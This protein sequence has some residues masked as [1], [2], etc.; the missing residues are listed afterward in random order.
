[1]IISKVATPSMNG[2]SEMRLNELDKLPEGLLDLSA[3]QLHA[4]LGGPTLI[5]MPGRQNPALY[6][7]VLM[8]GNED[9]GWEAIRGL[10]RRYQVGGGEQVLPRSLSLFIGNTAAAEVGVRHLEDQPDFN[11]IWPGCEN[12]DRPEHKVMAQVFDTMVARGLFA[13]IDVHNNTGMNPHHACINAINTPTLHMATLFSR[14]VVYFIRPKGVQSIAMTEL[15]P[16]I[17]LECGKVGMKH[18]V[19]HA[20][21]YIDAMLHLH[22]HPQHPVPKHDIDLFHHV[23]RVKVSEDTPFTFGEGKSQLNLMDD[24]ERM[25]FR[26]LA[27]GTRFAY[28]HDSPDFPL[29]VRNEQ[30][31]DVS[32]LY[33]EVV[34]GQL[35]TRTPVMPSMLTMDEMVIRQD[36]LCYLMERYDTHIDDA[37]EI[38]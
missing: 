21:E 7:S 37:L 38:T 1:M 27:A 25:N 4:E 35:R 14:T 12:P 28:V 29:D 8:H 23:A 9:V 34:D 31:H 20:A 10:L 33:F 19:E 22:E 2:R 11:R 17:T 36:C 15:C 24:L 30:G 32:E 16:A 13:C 18:G 5:H 26:E 6:V 3:P